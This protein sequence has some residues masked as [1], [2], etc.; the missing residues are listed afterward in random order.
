MI[1]NRLRQSAKRQ[2]F[3]IYFHPVGKGCFFNLCL[4]RGYRSRLLV[5]NRNLNGLSLQHIGLVEL[6]PVGNAVDFIAELVHLILNRSPVTVRIGPVRRLYGQNIPPLEHLVN[7]IH[8]A[9]GYLHHG[10]AIHGVI[11]TPVKSPGKLSHFLRNGKTG[12]IVRRPVDP[13]SGGKFLG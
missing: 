10:T 13:V 3:V 7:F 1:V 8:G 9:V 11:G 5:G 6:R 4:A 2:G 12:S